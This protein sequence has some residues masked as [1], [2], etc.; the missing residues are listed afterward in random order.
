MSGD[1]VSGRQVHP[2]RSALRKTSQPTVARRQCQLPPCG[3]YRCCAS[4]RSEL[5]AL[6]EVFSSLGFWRQPHPPLPTEKEKVCVVAEDR[7]RMAVAAGDFSDGLSPPSSGASGGPRLGL[8]TATLSPLGP[9]G[10]RRGARSDRRK[11][12]ASPPEEMA[13]DLQ[14]FGQPD[15]N[16]KG[17]G[18]RA[19]PRSVR[20]GQCVSTE[21]P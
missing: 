1:P 18:A 17:P 19:P 20:G 13:L 9:P 12:P 21:N 5:H 2:V 14:S 8:G 15:G 7:V 3:C 16:G 11:A 4:R 6:H 10:V